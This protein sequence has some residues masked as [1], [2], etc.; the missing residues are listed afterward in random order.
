[1]KWE[2]GFRLLSGILA[3][4]AAQAG[5]AQAFEA[6]AE[7][8]Y[9][10]KLYKQASKQEKG[11]YGGL[12]E[13][14]TDNETVDNWTRLITLHYRQGNV[15]GPIAWANAMKAAM[16]KETPKPNYSLEASGGHGYAEIIYEPDAKN[17]D[18][19]L[20]VTKTFHLPACN[21]L[22]GL[23]YAI[24]RSKAT[25]PAEANPK[26]FDHQQLLQFA[27]QTHDMKAALQAFAWT[28]KC[29]KAPG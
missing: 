9:G 2:T 23:Q 25:P 12:Y 14:T 21:G 5:F 3:L 17:A 6:P 4:L 24:K 26:E 29:G 7:I 20:N 18:Y 11:G 22:V 13:Y 16:D 1:M 10:G 15:G 19:E 28:P 27:R 8:D